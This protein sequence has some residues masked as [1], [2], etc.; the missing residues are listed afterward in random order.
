MYKGKGGSG[1]H[2]YLPTTTNPCLSLLGDGVWVRD[3]IRE[4]KKKDEKKIKGTTKPLMTNLDRTLQSTKWVKV[5]L[6]Q[7]KTTHQL[8]HWLQYFHKPK[9]STPCPRVSCLGSAW[10]KT[11][12]TP[13]RS[14][15]SAQRLVTHLASNEKLGGAWKSYSSTSVIWQGE[16][17]INE[18][19]S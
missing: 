11:I 10:H 13:S 15:Y 8:T 6:P 14:F 7:C 19:P 16:E 12:I 18:I 2:C 4:G 5:G 3:W 1:R 17:P 9:D